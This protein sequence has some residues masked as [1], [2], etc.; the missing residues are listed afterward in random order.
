[1]E[2]AMPRLTYVLLLL[3][4][5]FAASAYEPD[6]ALMANYIGLTKA[7]RA[8]GVEPVAVSWPVVESMCLGLK[9]QKSSVRYNRCRFDAALNQASFGDDRAACLD[10]AQ[11]SSADNAM[12]VTA[13]NSA[14]SQQ[15]LI[16]TPSY[17]SCMRDLGWRSPNNWQRGR[18]AVKE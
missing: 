9:T 7:L 14:V 16:V 3:L 17:T 5:P 8:N 15:S 11:R 4:M 6:D 10:D 1:M 2:N 12:A 13:I 18:V